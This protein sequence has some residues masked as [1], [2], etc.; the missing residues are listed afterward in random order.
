M[1]E[2]WSRLLDT[3]DFPP[4]WNCG[5]WTEGHGWLHIL[6]DIGI[7][8]A[9][10]AIPAM[11]AYFMV[12]R[13]DLPFRKVFLLF[14]AFILLCGTTHLMEAIIFWWP[15]Y[16]L[17]GVIKLTTALVSWTTVLALVG[18]V[19]NFLRMRSPEELEREIAARQRAED[20]LQQT[21]A[22]LEHRVQQRTSELAA[23]NSVLQA[24]REW[25]RTTLASIGDAVITTDTEGRVTSLNAVAEQL[26]GWKQSAAAGQELTTVFRIVNDATR[27]PV[28][29]PAARALEQGM[30][31]G[32]ANH[33][34]LIAKDGA[35]RFIDDSAAPI[36]SE[37]GEVLGAVLIFR[38][39]SER[40][41]ADQALRESEARFLQL[42]DA[43]P[44]LAWMAQPDGHIDWYNSR[45]Y[46]Y[47]GK[48]VA[49]ME[50]WGWQSVHDPQVLPAVNQRWKESLATGNP[51]EMVFPLRGADGKFRHFL[52]RVMPF[53]DAHGKLTRW[54]GT[55]TDISAQ[56]QTQEELRQV[57]AKLSEADRRK[58]EFLATLAHELRNPLA[59]I[60]TGLELMKVVKDDSALLDEIRSAMERQTDQL[61]RLVDDL[62][63]V[64]RITHGKLELRTCR[65]KLADVMK[66]AIE[67]SRPMIDDAHHHLTVK[68]PDQPIEFDADPH[69][70]AQILSNLLN[71]SAK[72]TP[73]GGQISLTAERRGA[74]VMLTVADNGIGIPADMLDRVFQMFTQIQRPVETGSPGLGIGLTLVKSLVTMHGGSIEVHSDGHNQGSEFRI[75]L[76]ILEDVHSESMGTPDRNAPPN[77][78][79]PRRVLVVDDN[80]DAARTLSL[81]INVLG[82]EVRV[83]NDGQRAIEAAAE[84]LPDLILMDIGMPIMNGYDAARRIRQESWGKTITLVAL[85]GWGQEED[86]ARTKEAGFDHHLVKPADPAGIRKLLTQ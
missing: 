10:F 75:C 13:K 59:P 19:P 43:I 20:T 28:P 51:F 60:R 84:F 54:F 33:T 64:S 42:A 17:A 53:R 30:I 25:F 61:V 1:Y 83:A 3:S 7:W 58:D 57:A 69:R 38:D 37:S 12:R 46:E 23:A 31:V 9:Y 2:F 55:N 67:A 8:S 65:V 71:N 26:T 86:R 82:A 79:K 50:G 6:S 47:T 85:T 27:E 16:R 4:R 70:L 24:E 14:A 5:H 74:Q 62:L 45:W 52:T 34:L 21:N 72:Y 29:N 18:V 49:E 73:D 48:S 11:L 40:Y 78:A 68:L 44:Q 41:K 22:A 63:D 76:P 80:V 32:L 36:K 77:G 81:I 56:L 39:I 66:S 35:E 15:G